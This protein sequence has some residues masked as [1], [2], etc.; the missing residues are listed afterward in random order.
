[1]EW[2]HTATA[3][4]LK[5]LKKTMSTIPRG[6]FW[7]LLQACVQPI[8]KLRGQHVRQV[9]LEPSEGHSIMCM[10]PSP[11]AC[12]NLAV[13]LQTVAAAL[14]YL[15]KT[16]VGI[17]TSISN[18]AKTYFVPEKKLRQGLKGVKYQS[19]SQRRRRESQGHTQDESSLSESDD[20]DHDDG[21]TFAKIT[22]LKKTK[23]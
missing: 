10:L 7:L 4:T 1:M 21:A 20:N 2:A 9:K 6:P 13:P 16:E 8:I 18:T 17:E 14:A 12:K 19:G 15:I 23:K 22:P 5:E 3:A 11:A